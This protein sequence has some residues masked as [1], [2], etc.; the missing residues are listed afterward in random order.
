MALRRGRVM[1]AL[2][3]E[4]L[5]RKI[6]PKIY[7]LPDY[8]TRLSRQIYASKKPNLFSTLILMQIS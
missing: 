6:C 2:N 7:R 5:S 3:P 1:L 8:T 4:H